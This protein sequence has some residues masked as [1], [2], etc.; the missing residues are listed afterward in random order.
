MLSLD[1][2][3]GWDAGQLGRH[4]GPGWDAGQLGRHLGFDMACN[5]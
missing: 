3:P 4:L 1:L 5:N 2:G